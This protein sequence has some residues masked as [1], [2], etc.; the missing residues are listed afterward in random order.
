MSLSYTQEGMSERYVDRFFCGRN[1]DRRRGARPIVCRFLKNTKAS[2]S[3]ATR[4]R[5]K[6][7]S[8]LDLAL[9]ILRRQADDPAAPVPVVFNLASWDEKLPRFL[10][11][12]AAGAF[13][14]VTA[15]Q[16]PVAERLLLERR[17]LPFLDGLDEIGAQRPRRR[18]KVV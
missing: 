8:L 3:S 9:E 12:A 6:R 4:A 15:G 16:K 10:D 1:E 7:P 14:K 2:C 18:S 13:R 17:I 11:V 5:A